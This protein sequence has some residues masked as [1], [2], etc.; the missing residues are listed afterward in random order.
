MIRL[1]L[2]V[3]FV[4]ILNS[5]TTYGDRVAP[6]PLPSAQLNHLDVKGALLA[7]HPYADPESAEAVFGFDIR[8]AG[9]L[10]VRFVIDNQSPGSV[11]IEPNQTFLIDKEGQAWP[12]LTAEQAYRRVTNSVGVGEVFKGAKTPSVLL[13][14][15][16]AV[17]GFA[18]GILSGENVAEITAKGAVAGASLG[19]LYGGGLRYENLDYEIRTDLQQKSLRN[20]RI[21]RGDLAYGYLFF[22]GKQEAVSAHA[23][24]L[25]LIV[26]KQ[27]YVLNMPFR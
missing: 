23:L 14:A 21:R 4:A 22:P 6:V 25:G 17:A 12:L 16:G 3:S 2:L 13:G 24:R 1:V 5:C 15:A 7:A 19:A 11:N 26:N 18:I 27:R 20:Q 8:D 9:L 10:P